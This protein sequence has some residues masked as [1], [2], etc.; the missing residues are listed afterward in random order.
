MLHNN[1]CRALV[2][3]DAGRNCYATCIIHVAQEAFSWHIGHSI[4]CVMH[5]YTHLFH[6]EDQARLSFTEKLVYSLSRTVT[7]FF[8]YGYETNIYLSEYGNPPLVLSRKPGDEATA[9]AQA[10]VAGPCAFSLA[11][12]LPLVYTWVWLPSCI[13]I[14]VYVLLTHVVTMSLCAILHVE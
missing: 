7:D 8:S 2:S 5:G 13:T 12:A 3:H 4:H 10:E 6:R 11:M 9:G 1:A 14:K